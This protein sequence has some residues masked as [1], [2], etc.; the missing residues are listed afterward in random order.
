[1][2]ARV[3]KRSIEEARDRNERRLIVLSGKLRWKLK[4]LLEVLSYYLEISSKKEAE[5]VYL[6]PNKKSDFSRSVLN[7][8]SKQKNCKAETVELRDIDTLLGTNWDCMV[9]DMNEGMA[10]NDIGKAIGTVRGNGIIVMLMPYIED[11]QRLFT[12]FHKLLLVPPY[13]RKDVKYVF[14]SWFV[15]KLMQHD[16][17][18]IMEDDK[19]IKASKLKRRAKRDT[20]KISIPENGDKYLRRM[21]RLCLS[22]DQVDALGHMKKFIDSK[23]ARVFILT[24][25][26]GRGKSSVIGLLLAYLVANR[27]MDVVVTSP[28]R[29]NT[30]ELFKF[31]SKGLRKFGIKLDAWEKVEGKEDIFIKRTGSRVRYFPAYKARRCRADLVVVDEAAA[32]PTKIL[33]SVLERAPKTIYSTTLHGYEGAGRTFN[34]RFLRALE[35]MNVKKMESEMITPIRYAE[36]DPIEKWLF[37]VLLL[38]AEP[39]KFEPEEAEKVLPE[40]LKYRDYDISV[41]A[42]TDENKLREIFGIFVTAHYRNNPN[43]FGLLCDAPHHLIRALEYN[44]RVVCAVQ[45]AEEG[46]LE[47]ESQRM[48]YGYSPSG[49]LIPDRMIKHYRDVEFGKLRG[50]RI[51][52]IAVHPSLMSKGIG[53]KILECVTKEAVGSGYNWIGASFGATERL[54]NFWIKNGFRVVHIAPSVNQSTGEYSTI[55]IKPIDKRCK[56]FVKVVEKEFMLKLIDCLVDP[57]NELEPEIV[58]KVLEANR[59]I[60][61]DGV[62]LTRVQ[63]KRLAA[64]AFSTL[65]YESTRDC[66]YKLV[67]HHFLNENNKLRLDR[68]E[69]LLLIARVLQARSWEEIKELMGHG[70]TVFWMIELKD[71][72]KKLVEHYG[73]DRIDRAEIRK[74]EEEFRKLVEKED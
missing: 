40:K 2:L 5:L 33:F 50:L 36:T 11:Y 73:K 30:M 55:V 56:E 32:I 63:W 3:L 31:L 42:F 22:Q 28:E 34:I 13:T 61:D 23:N 48:Y 38:D 9:I 29:T 1:M 67:K 59:G 71:L 53:S 43:D 60:K 35:E 16:G 45:L 24:S 41:L 4:N 17:I 12:R 47:N 7:L 6:T 27:K 39:V 68:E 20:S 57:Y 37:D 72:M 64:Y 15:R 14:N 49:H 62:D 8:I 58:L 18:F 21:Y 70:G 66:V 74:L 51:V 65:T 69:N 46:G 10:P 25:H 52:R 54:L 44:S 19:L 26:R